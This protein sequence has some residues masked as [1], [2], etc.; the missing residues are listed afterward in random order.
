ML[1]QKLRPLVVVASV[2]AL[3]GCGGTE[4]VT[5]SKTTTVTE[6]LDPTADERAALR[7]RKEQLDKRAAAVRQRE[8]A[9]AREE[10]IIARSKFG[11]GV[12]LVGVDI[13]AGEYRTAGGASECYWERRQRGS[14]DEIEAYFGSGP[15]RAYVNAGELFEAQGCGTWRRG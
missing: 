14:T 5:A 6:T 15:A 8:R 2:L 10:R 7:K 1:M 9:V 12:Y 3:A 4:T 13:P 11:D